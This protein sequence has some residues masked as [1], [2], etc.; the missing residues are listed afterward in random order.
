MLRG[1]STFRIVCEGPLI[2]KIDRDHEFV[3]SFLEGLQEWGVSNEG[4]DL[5]QLDGDANDWVALL[6]DVGAELCLEAVV[7]FCLGWKCVLPMFD[8]PVAN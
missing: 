7:G 4:G 8:R 6:L 2:V 3:T 5:K 1:P